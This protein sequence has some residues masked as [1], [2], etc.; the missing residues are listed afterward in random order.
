MWRAGIISACPFDKPSDFAVPLVVCYVF[1]ELIHMHPDT[2]TWLLIPR[3]AGGGKWAESYQYCVFSTIFF[4]SRKRKLVYDIVDWILICVFTLFAHRICQLPHLEHS[5]Q[6]DPCTLN[7]FGTCVYVVD[8]KHRRSNLSHIREIRTRLA[9]DVILQ[10]DPKFVRFWHAKLH[11]ARLRVWKHVDGWEFAVECLMDMFE[12]PEWIV[13]DKLHDMISQY[14]QLF[15]WTCLLLHECWIIET[16][17]HN[18]RVNYWPCRINY[19]FRS[20]TDPRTPTNANLFTC[21]ISSLQIWMIAQAN[22]IACIHFLDR[23]HTQLEKKS[24][25]SLFLCMRI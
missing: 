14:N 19:L 15:C 1:D 23:I 2:F 10:T 25:F 18:W 6:H 24:P 13:S 9:M 20:N 7:S 22:Q 12:W 5:A 11:T 8:I 3:I 21:R 17:I 4:H 16:A